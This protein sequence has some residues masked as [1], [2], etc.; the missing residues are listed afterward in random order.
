MKAKI[1]QVRA[2]L[3]LVMLNFACL[4]WFNYQK[5]CNLAI[6]IQLGTTFATLLYL[7]FS[8]LR[9]H[10]SVDGWWRAVQEILGLESSDVLNKLALPVLMLDENQNVLWYNSQFRG[11]IIASQDIL[12][13]SLAEHLPCF[14]KIKL[15][16]GYVFEVLI[17][18]KMYQAKVSLLGFANPS[19]FMVCLFDVSE[20]E[21]LKIRHENGKTVI[22]SVMMD[23]L[24]II[25][26]RRSELE[27][28]RIEGDLEYVIKNYFE[29]LS[30]VA[31]KIEKDKFQVLFNQ[32]QLKVLKQK[33]FPILEL[34]RKADCN[35]EV[36]PTISMGVS[37]PADKTLEEREQEANKALEMALGRGGDQVALKTDNSYEFFGGVM[38][39]TQ[40]RSSV[41]VRVV[42]SAL[43]DLIETSNNLLVMGHKFADLDCFGAAIGIAKIAKS[44][45]KPVKL[46]VNQTTNM[47]G[48]IL[49]K[50]LA[51]SDYENVIVDPGELDGFV[52]SQT[53][54]VVVDLHVIKLVE[55]PEVFKI[56]RN[57]V[58]ID[59]HRKM[60]DHIDD[61][62]I[63][64]H[65]PFASS[66]SEMVTELIRYFNREIKLTKLEA[67]A[68][69]SGIV[70]D[71]KGFVLKTGARTFRAAALLKSAGADTIEIK[72]AFAA[73]VDEH[74]RV[75]EIM[76]VAKI[77]HG[78]AVSLTKGDWLNSRLLVA[79]AADN[80]L[81]IQDVDASFVIC[82]SGQGCLISA[83]SLGKVNVQVI[84]EALGGGGHQIMAA[85]QLHGKTGIET[86]KLLTAQLEKL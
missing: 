67:E 10:R 63:F 2:G 62:V 76:A 17:A 49:K 85:A 4:L 59:H 8:V 37:E 72:K 80:L 34:V 25:L 33:K 1:F 48:P 79:K 42:A 31:W 36:V 35:G 58:V 52:N 22:A 54:I 16:E 12:N 66:A 44:F 29:E 81:N 21:S 47:I 38:M 13:E 78:C 73:T 11:Q 7:A 5:C 14:A 64:H 40:Q 15:E 68:L 55:C 43:S 77:V 46:V 51:S 27:R 69:L 84:M 70:L 75:S 53:L 26:Q 57:I 23:N 61:A 39:D 65:E 74:K 86:L 30:G 56:A 50:F 19:V 20:F 82:E 71:T 60:V 41:R 18:Q 6:K 28:V 3:I 83:R 24:D 45:K 32:E 9:E